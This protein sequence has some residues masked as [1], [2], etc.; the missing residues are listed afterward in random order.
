MPSEPF[1]YQRIVGKYLED[2]L[3]K[4]IRFQSR[5]RSL[6]NLWLSIQAQAYLSYSTGCLFLYQQHPL[7]VVSPLGV[8]P[9]QSMPA[10]M[11]ESDDISEFN[12]PGN[13]E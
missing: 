8:F 4:F 5:I 13:H 10:H 12:Y 2:R 1:P 7:L 11:E 3:A 6:Y 9:F